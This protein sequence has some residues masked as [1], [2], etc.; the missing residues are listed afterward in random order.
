M[1]A[2]LEAFFANGRTGT[3]RIEI[4]SSVALPSFAV[5]HLIVSE[6]IE[7][8]NDVLGAALLHW[9]CSYCIM[10]ASSTA[11]IQY[12]AH[13]SVVFAPGLADF[14]GRKAGDLLGG[15]ISVPR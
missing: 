1:L 6:H 10:L 2:V 4:L 3:L 8:L 13:L 12:R 5:L 9:I 11:Q 7:I 15:L 14:V